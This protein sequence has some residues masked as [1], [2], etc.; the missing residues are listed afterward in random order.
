MNY[1]IYGPLKQIPIEQLLRF[2]YNFHEDKKKEFTK[3]TEF[4]E[5]QNISMI[6]DGQH[7]MTM[8][9]DNDIKSDKDEEDDSCTSSLFNSNSERSRTT[10][11]DSSASISSL[12]SVS[13]LL[14]RRERRYSS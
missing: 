9:S 6:N 1:Q 3:T 11:A 2:S 14:A 12:G 7:F 10:S 13:R 8:D 4:Q 5:S